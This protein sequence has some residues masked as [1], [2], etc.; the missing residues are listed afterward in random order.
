MQFD[1]GA[2]PADARI[3]SAQV[4][5]MGMSRVYFDPGTGGTWRL[6]LL[7]SSVDMNWTQLN[8]Y[9]IHNAGVKAMSPTALT[10]A[11]LVVGD[12]NTFDVTNAAPALQE[13][14]R[15]TRR[16]SFRISLD[17]SYGIG[18]TIFGWTAQPVLRITYTR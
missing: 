17:S 8:Y 6:S 7:D 11:D 3:T 9:Q 16:A 5:L 18:R 13:R 2:L 4:S 1:L 10:G 14:L 15:T 12:A